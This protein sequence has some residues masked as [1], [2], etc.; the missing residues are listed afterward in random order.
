MQFIQRYDPDYVL[1]LSGDHIYKMNYAKMLSYHIEKEASCTIGVLEVPK[2]EVSRFGIM[3][4]R[5]DDRIYEFQ[6]KTA[7]SESRLASMGI[8]IFNMSTLKQYLTDDNNDPISSKDF[9]KNIIPTMLKAEEP[10]FAYPFTGYWK[11]VGTIESLWEANMDL[12][13]PAVPL[14]LNDATWKIYARNNG[15]PPQFIG[16]TAQV[17]NSI[18]SEGVEIYG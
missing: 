3:S 16:K 12:L 10:L 15:Q 1:I 9:C 8:Y 2:E 13:N 17:Q 11:D 7:E 4:V 5:E 6:E 14:D 18:V